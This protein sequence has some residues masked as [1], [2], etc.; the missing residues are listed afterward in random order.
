MKKV[1]IVADSSCDLHSRD[2]TDN[3]IDF[4]TVPIL[5]R[6]GETDYQD[7]EDSDVSTL[8]T[9]MKENKQAPK[10]ACPS[11]ETFAETFRAATTKQ[12]FVLT[13]SS[14]LS[15]TYNSARLAAEEVPD[16][17]IFVFDSLNTSAGLARIILKLADLIKNGETDF[18]TLCEKLP[19]IRSRNRI[20]FFLHDLGNLVKSGRMSKVL[21]IITSVIPLKLICGD[22]GEGEIKKYKQVLGAKKGIEAL[23][24]FPSND[25]ATQEDLIVISHCNNTEGVGT[26]KTILK[27]LG[28]KNIKTLLMRGIATFFANEKGIAIA[29]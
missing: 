7:T 14:K 11:V 26:I 13:L 9:R 19:E 8:T 6:L 10:T 29:Y 21:G 1:T 20:R 28:F 23:A 22:N 3:L 25:N 17:Q 2:L 12:I 18:E 16:K 4:V 24:Q 5:Y 15:G 27:K